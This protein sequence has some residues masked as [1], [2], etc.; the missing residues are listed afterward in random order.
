MESRVAI[1]IDVK[2]DYGDKQPS[3]VQANQTKLR[4]I[5]ENQS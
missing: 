4:E 3:N 2:K 1:S 5:T